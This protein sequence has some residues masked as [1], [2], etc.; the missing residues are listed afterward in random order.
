MEQK[1]TNKYPTPANG[2]RGGMR[3]RDESA[4]PQHA[5]I[6]AINPALNHRTSPGNRRS[7]DV[8]SPVRGND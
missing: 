8:K 4:N 1:P 7:A 5:W 6:I 3:A 2:F